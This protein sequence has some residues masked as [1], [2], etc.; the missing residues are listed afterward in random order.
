[1]VQVEV[2]WIAGQRYEGISSEGQHLL[3]GAAGEA[4]VRPAEALLLALGSCAAYDIVVILAKQRATLQRLQVQVS[5]E[6]RAAPPFSYT[7]IHLRFRIAAANLRPQR[8]E[9]AVDLALNKY[10]AVR[11]SLDPAIAVSFSIEND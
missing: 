3:L 6:Q 4:G 9:R 5:G 8:L 2:N 7:S 1:M 10:C 11:A